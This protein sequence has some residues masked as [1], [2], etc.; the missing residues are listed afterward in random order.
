M[1][2]SIY[3][4]ANVAYIGGGFGASVHNVLEAAVYGVPVMFGNNYQKSFECIDLINAQAAFSI[5]SKNELQEKITALLQESLAVKTGEM[6]RSYV[7]NRAGGTEKI[8]TF[9][10][11][12]LIG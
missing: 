1:L 7:M 2:S 12:Q 4:Y 8:F 9:V 11:Q 6:A 5:S 3:A 10:E